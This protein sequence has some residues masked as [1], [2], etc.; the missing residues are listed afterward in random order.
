[1]IK[2]AL[3]GFGYWGKKY[4]KLLTEH[5]NTK[6]T[7]VFDVKIDSEIKTTD[8][9][10]RFLNPEALSDNN[11]F[12]VAIIATPA[13]THRKIIMDLAS[14]G[15]SVL[16]E[17]PVVTDLRS[18]FDI[19]NIML[20]NKDFFMLPGLTYF[21]NPAIEYI[22]DNYIASKP[23]G[24]PMYARA[25]RTNWGPFREDVSAFT[26]L[27]IH[28]LTIL[29]YLFGTSDLISFDTYFAGK[30]LFPNIASNRVPP[31][32][33]SATFDFPEVSNKSF[34]ANIFCSWAEPKKTRL[35]RI[36]F[37]NG[38]V[39]FD[40]TKEFPLKEYV[41][42]ATDKTETS[43]VIQFQNNHD[44]LKNQLDFFIEL[45]NQQSNQVLERYEDILEI[46]RSI[47]TH[48]SVIENPRL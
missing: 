2:V 15:K 31:S 14:L 22:Y 24:Q 28:D 12:D 29:E 37:E 17:K 33:G 16:C 44:S 41:G 13:D 40:E 9:H 27:A 10:V 43:K 34:K 26:D 46:N 47:T 23:L 5:Q 38:M 30:Q 21:H 19:E 18:L 1:M 7:H 4:Y 3:F 39:E 45:Y 11:D 8:K 35:F 42:N 48:I 36:V 32:A 25:I 20:K 6:I